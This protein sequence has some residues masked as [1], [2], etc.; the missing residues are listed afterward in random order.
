MRKYDTVRAVF[1]W[2]PEGKRQRGRTR[3]RRIDGLAE[4]LNAMGTEVLL[5]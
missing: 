5:A 4:G 3:K 2:E 1:E